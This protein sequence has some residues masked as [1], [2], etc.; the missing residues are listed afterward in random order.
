MKRIKTYLGD[1]VR[2][3]W[4]MDGRLN[5]YNPDENLLSAPQ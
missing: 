5:K 4:Q 2:R 3:S 1:E